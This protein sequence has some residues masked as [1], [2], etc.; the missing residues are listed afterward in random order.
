MHPAVKGF[1]HL[2]VDLPAKAGQAPKCR[3]DVTART[4][5]AIVQIEVAQGGVD[6]VQPHQAHHTAA[7]PDAFGVAGRAID[8]LRRLGEFV[9]LALVVLGPVRRLRRVGIAGLP[10]WSWARLSPLWAT[11]VTEPDQQY[12][13]GADKGVPNDGF[14]QLKHPTTHKFPDWLLL[15]PAYKLV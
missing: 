4:A 10:D 5:K 3:L 1:S 2:W 12:K 6:V 13:G 15:A 7:E 8:G 9:G 14:L 11:A